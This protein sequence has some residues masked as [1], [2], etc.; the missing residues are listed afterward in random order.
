MAQ[1]GMRHACTWDFTAPADEMT[2]Q[3]VKDLLKKYCKKWCFQREVGESGYNHYQ[4]RI[5]LKV[6][7]RLTQLKDYFVDSW[8]WSPTS[9]ENVNNTFYVMKEDTREEGPW[10]D[11]DTYVPRQIRQIETLRPWQ[12]KIVDLCD[13]WDTRTV[14][15]IHDQ[16]GN[17]GKSTLVGWVRTKKI[18]RVIPYCNDFEKIMRAVCNLPTSKAYM[19]DMPRALEKKKLFQFYAGIEEIKNGYAYD[20]RYHFKEKYFD[21]P[22]VFIFTN[23]LPEQSLLSR[24]RWKICKVVDDQLVIS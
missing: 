23:V 22:Q 12:Q 20:E 4:G 2:V 21:C 11:E 19:F 7:A 16:G 13:V 1:K 5:S 10:S 24:D 6:K 9:N 8:H 14:Y 18:A 3:E 17:I 15:V